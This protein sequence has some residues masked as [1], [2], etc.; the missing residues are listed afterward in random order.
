MRKYFARDPEIVPT[1][2]SQTSFGFPNFREFFFSVYKKFVK[3]KNMRWLKLTILGLSVLVVRSTANVIA[4]GNETN[5]NSIDSYRGDDK[6]DR[7]Q[8]D[9]RDS[10]SEGLFGCFL[11]D[12]I[13]GCV[14]KRLARQIDRTEVEVTG[15]SPSISMSKVIE[16]AGSVVVDGLEA[17]L[18]SEEETGDE[19]VD[20]S[21]NDDQEE[22]VG[23][24]NSDL[25]APK[26][27]S[28]FTDRIGLQSFIF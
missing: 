5:N 24:L 13:F 2:S 27:R 6:Q 9:K 17:M 12:N 7:L 11:K 3:K 21:D 18:S 10:G 1:V 16:E 28:S 23:K 22:E 25:K 14:G 19:I 4:D 15:R 26:I 20:P 8:N